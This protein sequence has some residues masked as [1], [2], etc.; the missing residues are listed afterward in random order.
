MCHAIG[1]LAGGDEYLVRFLETLVDRI[2]VRSAPYFRCEISHELMEHMDQLY[3]PH[4]ISENRK[5]PVMMHLQDYVSFR[6]E[7]NLFLNIDP[8]I[9]G[10][11]LEATFTDQ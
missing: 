2:R 11:M 10:T 4:A 6:H 9:C 3:K 1:N 8:C 5:W 7:A